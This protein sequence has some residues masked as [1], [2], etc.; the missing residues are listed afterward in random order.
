MKIHYERSGGFAAITLR[1]SLDSADLPAA[2]LRR[3]ES[4]L[5]KARFFELPARIASPDG[6]PDRFHYRL[7]VETTD[8]IRTVEASEP[9]ISPE[10]RRLLDWI[11]RTLPAR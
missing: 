4:L 5:Q 3:L 8:G 1:R 11:T 10:L 9:A 7:T 2:D 6:G